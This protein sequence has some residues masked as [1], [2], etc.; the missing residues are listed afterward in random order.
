MKYKFID[1][2]ADVMFEAFGSSL[3]KVFENAA[4]ATFEVQC[5]LKKIEKKI[6]KKIKLKSKNIEDLLFDFIEELI[7]LKDARYIVFNEFDVKV[8]RK[9][10]SLEAEAYGEKINPRKH[11]LKVDVKAITLH[12]YYLKKVKNGWKCRIILDI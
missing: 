7:Y 6:E 4:L 5:D 3:S 2:T 11:E 1:H 12:H 8:D 10:V 9:N